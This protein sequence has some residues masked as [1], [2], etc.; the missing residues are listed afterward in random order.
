MNLRGNS[1]GHAVDLIPYG[2]ASAVFL[3]AP[4]HCEEQDHERRSHR[5]GP[6]FGRDPAVNT[7]GA[8]FFHAQKQDC[9]GEPS[10]I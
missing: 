1:R 4:R 8:I 3:F 5:L 6:A 7:G 9:F 10:I 2:I